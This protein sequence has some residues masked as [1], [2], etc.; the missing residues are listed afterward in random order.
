MQEKVTEIFNLAWDTRNKD[1]KGDK[2][3][4]ELKSSIAVISGKFDEYK[5]YRKEK[6]KN[7]KLAI[8]GGQ[9]IEEKD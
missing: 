5:K 4:E 2:Q 3:L 8:E 9:L 6:D 1:I 7:H